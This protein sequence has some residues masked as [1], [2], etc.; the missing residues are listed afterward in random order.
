VISVCTDVVMRAEKSRTIE[1]MQA[2]LQDLQARFGATQRE[3]EE[4]LTQA[5]D[6]AASLRALLDERDNA[7]VAA[8]SDTRRA[9]D[10]LGDVQIR[11]MA[12]TAALARTVGERDHVISSLQ[13]HAVAATGR[14]GETEAELG[15]RT[16]QVR[17]L[18][19]TLSLQDERDR[20]RADAVLAAARAARAESAPGVSGT[21]ISFAHPP[22]R[23]HAGTAPPLAVPAPAAAPAPAPAAGEGGGSGHAM[24]VPPLPLRSVAEHATAAGDGE[25]WTAG[26]PP[27]ST[28]SL[29]YASI[30]FP[31]LPRFFAHKLR[32]YTEE[33]ERQL[34]AAAL[35]R[36]AL[37]LRGVELAA[38]DSDFE[39][40][41]TAVDDAFRRPT[42]TSMGASGSVSVAHPAASAAG[43]AGLQG[44]IDTLRQRILDRLKTPARGMSPDFAALPP[45][46]SGGATPGVRGLRGSSV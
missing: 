10:N 3:S 5:F 43:V 35:S 40:R 23:S 36:A 16:A 20:T 31:L 45:T 13:R 26:A 41:R 46:L 14:L 28:R 29:T 39:Q 6:I 9:V 22:E 37:G 32:R 33:L 15:T 19:Q 8:A 38:R 30:V 1:Q 25:R 42:N 4:K 21:D 18:Q 34:E 24:H 27:A 17:A 2:A 12:D 11:A 7:L 44:E